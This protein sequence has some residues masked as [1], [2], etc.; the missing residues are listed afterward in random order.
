MAFTVDVKDSV[1]L[2]R[3]DRPLAV[4]GLEG[5]IVVDAGDAILVCPKDRAQYVRKIVEALEKQGKKKFL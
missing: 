3:K 2:A 1:V 5:M 4:I